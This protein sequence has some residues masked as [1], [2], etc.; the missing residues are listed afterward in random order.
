MLG[1]G[2]SVEWGWKG[3]GVVLRCWSLNRCWVRVTVL[4]MCGWVKGGCCEQVLEP[5]YI[6]VL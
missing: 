1:Q 4:S 6:H 2:D 5:E 3:F